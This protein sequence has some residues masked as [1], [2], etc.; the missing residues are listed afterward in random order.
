LKHVLNLSA[1]ASTFA[2]HNLTTR[3]GRTLCAFLDW[4]VQAVVNRHALHRKVVS[5][6]AH[7][8]FSAK[9]IAFQIAAV[10]RAY[11]FYSTT[12]T[13][14][15]WLHALISVLRPLI[16]LPLTYSIDEVRSHSDTSSNTSSVNTLMSMIANQQPERAHNS[17]LSGVFSLT[18]R[19]ALE[20][21]LESRNHRPISLPIPN[22]ARP[23]NVF[24][25]RPPPSSR[26]SVD[27]C[28]RRLDLH[29][30]ETQDLIR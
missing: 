17:K 24:T 16:K 7:P 1:P 12:N 4:I 30:R 13:D 5:S 23:D 6:H 19:F 14:D 28:Q 8:N 22:T 27:F 15:L 2:E 20:Q 11:S 29:D 18:P 10:R 26:Y 3:I 9:M 21:E 25:A